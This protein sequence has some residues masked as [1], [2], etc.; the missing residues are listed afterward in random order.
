[1]L[2]RL[3]LI[4]TLLVL[5]AVAVMI[6]LGFWQIERADEKAALLARYAAIQQQGQQAADWNGDP[7]T[8]E[9]MLFHTVRVVCAAVTVAQPVAGHNAKGETGWSQIGRCVTRESHAVTLVIGWSIKPDPFVPG[10]RRWA[11]GEVTGTVARDRGDTVRLIADPPLESLIANARPDP[12]NLPN[13]H[14]SYAVQWF[15]F[16]ATALVIYG[17]ALRKRLAVKGTAG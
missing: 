8:G 1:M 5:I 3:P 17:L 2:K 12:A 14:W 4:P 11:G 6:R 10:L 13:N 15:L 16:A 9:T 7:K